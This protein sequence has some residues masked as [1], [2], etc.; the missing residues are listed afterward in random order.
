MI[1]LWV[2]IGYLV[3]L[4]SISIWKSFME[5][6]QEDF[7]VNGLFASH[8]IYN[9]SGHGIDGLYYGWS[10][11]H[12]CPAGGIYMETGYRLR[13]GCVHCHGYEYNIDHNHNKLHYGI[14]SWLPITQRAVYYIAGSIGIHSCTYCRFIAYSP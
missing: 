13:R 9:H 2:V 14:T 6:S 8:T 5:K 3:I 12:P 10:G 11:P 1:F 4:M 7:M